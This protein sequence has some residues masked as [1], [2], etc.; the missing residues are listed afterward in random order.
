MLLRVQVLRAQPP[1]L[2]EFAALYFRG[3]A[4]IHDDPIQEFGSDA[5][6]LFAWLSDVVECTLQYS[7]GAVRHM[8]RDMSTSCMWTC[9]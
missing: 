5:N 4:G 6:G 1:E 7:G 8:S 9:V 2:Y 3:K